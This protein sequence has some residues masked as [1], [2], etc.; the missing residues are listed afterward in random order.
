MLLRASGELSGETVDLRAVTRGAAGDGAVGVPHAR[1]LTAFAESLVAGSEE[2]LAAARE[3]LG[4]AM[5]PAA[6]VD[7]AA[8]AA[9]FQ[10]MVRIA[11]ATGIP[12]DAPLELMTQ[13]L[14]AELGLAAFGSSANTPAAGWPSRVLGRLLRPAARGVIRAYARLRGARPGQAAPRG[15]D[16]RPPA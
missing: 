9:N 10:R 3:A 8:V 2:E 15:E 6:L 16:P 7:A 12:L 4:A 5:G 11:D 1:E 13:D 14:R